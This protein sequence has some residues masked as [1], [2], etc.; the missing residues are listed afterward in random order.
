MASKNLLCVESPVLSSMFDGSSQETQE[1]TATLQE[2]EGALSVQS[3]EAR[4][5]KLYLCTIH[6]N[7]RF[8]QSGIEAATE[9]ARLAEM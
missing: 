8:E 2:I 5:R 6:V 1:Q 3:F 9:L 7:D 4:L